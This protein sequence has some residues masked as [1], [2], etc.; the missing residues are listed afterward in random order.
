MNY[1][2]AAQEKAKRLIAWEK[3]PHYINYELQHL[4]T[5]IKN[6]TKEYEEPTM[7]DQPLKILETDLDLLFSGAYGFGAYYSLLQILAMNANANVPAGIMQLLGALEYSCRGTTVRKLWKA[8][9]E[10][11]KIAVNELI[12]KTIIDFVERE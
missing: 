1:R 11:R 6:L 12:E 3:D 8:L 10:E 9:P 2:K 4:N 5:K 7:F